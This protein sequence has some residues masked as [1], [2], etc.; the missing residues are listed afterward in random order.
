M[1]VRMTAK[2]TVDC[3]DGIQLNRFQPGYEYEIGAQLADLMIVEGWAEPVLN[4]VE[5]REQVS[6]RAHGRPER[7]SNILRLTHGR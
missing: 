7:R 6:P 3:I 1:R 5:S 4:E 2:P